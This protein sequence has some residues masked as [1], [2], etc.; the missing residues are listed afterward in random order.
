MELSLKRTTASENSTIGELSIN[1]TFECYTLED[2]VRP[3]KMAGLT[4][5]PSGSYEVVITYSAR[6]KRPMPLLLKVPDFDGV[7]I[8]WGNTDEDTEGCILVG[9]TKSKDFIGSSRVA[10]AQLFPKL[11]AASKIEK[12]FIEIT[13]VA[14]DSMLERAPAVALPKGKSKGT[15]AR[16]RTTAKK[17]R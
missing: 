17:H 13:N 5:I 14:S 16:K 15:V 6:F 3:V 8:H 4:A 12:I 2:V 7:R 11:E 10:F 1:D 9:K